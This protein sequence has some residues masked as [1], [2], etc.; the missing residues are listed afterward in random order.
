VD[1]GRDDAEIAAPPNPSE[2][3]SVARDF[4][5]S[6]IIPIPLFGHTYDH[7]SHLVQNAPP[8]IP[9]CYFAH[10]PAHPAPSIKDFF[11]VSIC[12]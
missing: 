5:V 9:L 4:E 12:F 2:I 10:P 6:R 11:F 1:R 8:K 7:R 3:G